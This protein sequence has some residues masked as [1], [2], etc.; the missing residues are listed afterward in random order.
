MVRIFE[1]LCLKT[2]FRNTKAMVCTS[3]FIWGQQG[4]DVYKRKATGEGP[5][6]REIKRT[7]VSYEE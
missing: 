1:R 6:F 7:R 3:G 2:N 4:V 5:N